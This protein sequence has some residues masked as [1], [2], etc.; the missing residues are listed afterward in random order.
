M[1]FPSPQR[2]NFS[3]SNLAP[4]GGS[5]V[6]T[7]WSDPRMEASG[8]QPTRAKAGSKGEVSNTSVDS[9]RE[10]RGTEFL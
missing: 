2:Q 1:E 6:I 9:L 4:S 5:H 10:K 8:P 3:L 7:D